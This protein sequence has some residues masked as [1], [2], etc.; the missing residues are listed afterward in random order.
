[1]EFICPITQRLMHTPVEAA[2]GKVYEATAISRWFFQKESELGPAT[3]PYTNLPLST[4]R[5]RPC[6]ELRRRINVF[7]LEHPEAVGS[8]DDDDA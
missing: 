1:M 3:S 7:R 8:D 5:V 4:T 2:D 6:D